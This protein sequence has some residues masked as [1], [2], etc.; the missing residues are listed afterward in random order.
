MVGNRISRRKL[1]RTSGIGIAT[2]GGLASTASA[3]ED[4]GEFVLDTT[5]EPGDWDAASRTDPFET[6][7][8]QAIGEE[9][10][11]PATVKL[12]FQDT[13][14]DFEQETPYISVD[15]NPLGISKT[16][17]IDGAEDTVWAYVSQSPA[18][19]SLWV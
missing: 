15:T 19:V 3:D 1:I 18:Q 7:F 2:L 6:A 10:D 11:E 13:K 9:F 5:L 14:P 17:H 12:W 8:F 4:D 16:L